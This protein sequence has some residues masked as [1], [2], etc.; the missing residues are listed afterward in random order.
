MTLYNDGIGSFEPA[1]QHSLPDNRCATPDY[2][3]T[4]GGA[5]PNPPEADKLLEELE[6]DLK[7]SFEAFRT[8]PR[9]Y[10][11]GTPAS[12]HL[13]ADQFMRRFLYWHTQETS[14]N[15]IPR[16]KVMEA[17]DNMEQS[18][19]QH[20]VPEGRDLVTRSYVKNTINFVRKALDGGLE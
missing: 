7:N 6:T 2:K 13:A 16:Q 9:G 20:T 11:Q 12:S 5:N 4:Y 3:K 19:N 17:I 1:V 15:F 8:A 14:R 18:I 10:S